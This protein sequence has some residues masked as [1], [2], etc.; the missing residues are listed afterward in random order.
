MKMTREHTNL[1]VGERRRENPIGE[2]GGVKKGEFASGK[3]NFAIKFMQAFL[4]EMQ[5]Y[6]S[7]NALT[8]LK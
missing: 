5:S 1:V 7:F 3:T 4:W 2:R 8:Y 6:R